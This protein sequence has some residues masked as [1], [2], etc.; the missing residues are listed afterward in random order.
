VLV[1][2][3]GAL[4]GAARPV[5]ARGVETQVERD[6]G[7]GEVQVE[8][9]EQPVGDVEGADRVEQVGRGLVADLGAAADRHREGI[10]AEV[11]AVDAVN[12]VVAPG[13]ADV[14]QARAQGLPPLGEGPRRDRIVDAH[15]GV[16]AAS[17]R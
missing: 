3:R 5:L 4:H 8:V 1:G 2:H 11:V 14:E 16:L 7:N 10:M 6:D 17:Q 15:E 12:V 9:V 13:D